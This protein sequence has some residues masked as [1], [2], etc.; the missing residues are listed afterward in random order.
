MKL[1]PSLQKASPCTIKQ[2]K[3]D[4]GIKPAQS[5]ATAP[6]S[7]KLQPDANGDRDTPFISRYWL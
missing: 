7:C 2:Q 3:Q 5:N 1:T 6:T 4:H